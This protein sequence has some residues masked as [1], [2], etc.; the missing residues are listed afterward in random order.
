MEFQQKISHYPY[1][2]SLEFQLVSIQI[3]IS[4]SKR[5][6]SVII[7]A[8]TVLSNLCPRIF[9]LPR[10]NSRGVE[11][12]CVHVSTL[13]GQK[14]PKGIPN[15]RVSGVEKLTRSFCGVKHGL[16]LQAAACAPLCCKNMCCASR[17]CMGGRGAAGSR[18]K[19]LLEGAMKQIALAEDKH[20]TTNVQNG[21]SFSCYSLLFTFILFNSLSVVK[22]LNSKKKAWKKD[23][24]KL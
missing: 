8:T 13:G 20:A 2:L 11:L 7:S 4:G 5:I 9:V 3:Q 18:S 17:F 12:L 16:V 10:A 1:R 6:N 24:E 15:K 23:S 22:P 14:K 21:W 19:N